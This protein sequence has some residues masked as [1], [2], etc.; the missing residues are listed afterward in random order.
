MGGI[1]AIGVCSWSLKVTSIPE[2]QKLMKE[3]GAAVTQVALGDPNHA[4]W[5]EGE[6]IVRALRASHLDI[7][8]TMIGYPGE[9]Y[10]TPE[11]IR[12]TGGFGDP[13]T[14]VERLAMFRRAVDMTAELGVKILASHAG[15]IPPSGDPSRG[16]FLDCLYDAADYALSK[17]VIFAMETGQE[18][19]E[20]LRRTIDEIAVDSLKVNFD[21]ANMI[22]YDMG[23]PIHAIEILGPDIVHVHVKDARAPLAEG[24]WGEEVP[25]GEGQ[26]GMQEFLEALA[27]VDY[28]GPLVVER[29][30]GDQAQRIEDIRNGVHLI[31]K[32]ITGG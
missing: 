17:D 11:T 2:L 21:P 24:A 12:R 4:T 26:V 8:A 30:V 29:E 22:L 13:S 14:R 23:D 20:L 16:S 10:T 27:A 7:T 3:V 1:P 31:R 25:L 15:F 19:A 28:G 9:D 18:T 32:L 6:G 5:K